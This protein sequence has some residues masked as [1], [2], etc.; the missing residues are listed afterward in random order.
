MIAA[1][2]TGYLDARK[3]LAAGGWHL[4]DEQILSD[5]MDEIEPEVELR[6]LRP[7]WDAKLK[8]GHLSNTPEA[9]RR[10]AGTRLDAIS[11]FLT[12]RPIIGNAEVFDQ[13]WK[14]FRGLLEKE[15][16]QIVS[17]L[18]TEERNRR[19]AAPFRLMSADLKTGRG[20]I[21]SV[22]LL[23]WR[24]RLFA[25]QHAPTAPVEIEQRLRAELTRARSA[26]QAAAGRLHDTYDFDLRERAAAYLGVDVHELGR[27]ILSLQRETEERVDID[28]PEVR[29][30]RRLE[31]PTSLDEVL[32]SPDRL[33]SAAFDAAVT[34]V[35]PDWSR[36][37]DTPHVVPFHLH[38]VGEHSR[39][40]VDELRRLLSS[41]A[42]AMSAEAASSIQSP[43]TLLWAGLA[44]DIGKGAGEPH[45]RT[46]ARIVSESPLTGHV[47]EPDLLVFLIEHH[48]LLADF[49]TR[50]DIDDP[51]VVSWVAERFED[52]ASLAALYLLTIA[53]S[54]ATGTDTWNEWRSELVRRAYRKIERELR[55]RRMPEELQVELLSD[56]VSSAAP[57][58]PV[59]EI[60]RH[61]AGFGEVYR[62]GHS[63]EE[64]AHHIELAK[65]PR[66]PG[67]IRIEVTPGNPATMIVITDDRPGLLLTVSGV[68]ALNRISITD[69]RFAT[70]SDGLV[71]DS[72]DIVSDDRTRIDD[73]TLDT[74]AAEMTAAIRRGADLA[75]AVHSK[76]EAYRPVE[77]SAFQ[78]EVTIEP[79]GVGGGRIAIETP[80]RIGLIHDLGR[81]FQAY[82]M[83]IKR[84]RVDTRGGIAYD[85]FWVDRLPA[86]RVDLERAL[87]EVLS[88]GS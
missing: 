40:C 28:W 29:E 17:M 67:E 81:V 60:R 83:P 1:P 54:I 47:E 64:I 50:Y 82:T 9:A 58:I 55:A 44:H 63:P 45:P 85:V 7:L 52:Q 35:L 78:P 6:I 25:L 31:P 73:E 86:D 13:F 75:D 8:V 33:T 59:A 42:D 70:R 88:V 51:A 12:S 10:F 14:L 87:M 77:Q 65:R 3:E 34:G 69:A 61:L 37:R 53:D 49:A 57:D 18:A 4:G 2:L 80:D 43:Q 16:A 62:R 76:R 72:F 26:I 30:K 22:D 68:L 36:L 71:F 48:L 39:A 27:T 15:H 46:G 56:R 66:T 32:E 79:E 5:R 20:G 74:L 23:D 11:T 24:R 41:E 21:R 19:E 84:A 38:P